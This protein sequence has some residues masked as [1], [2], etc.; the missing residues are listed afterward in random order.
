MFDSMA[1]LFD[2]PMLA[3]GLRLVLVAGGD[4]GWAGRSDGSLAPLLA[5][6]RWLRLGAG[7]WLLLGAGDHTQQGD[8][9]MRLALCR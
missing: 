5:A 6:V 9:W 3:A 8:W 7:G 4:L 2:C 1:R